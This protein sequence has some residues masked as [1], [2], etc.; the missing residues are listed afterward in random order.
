MGIRTLSGGGGG[1]AAAAAAAVAAVSQQGLE[2]SKNWPR[3]ISIDGRKCKQRSGI[4]ITMKL[5]VHV[6][7]FPWH[8]SRAPSIGKMV[9]ARKH[10][11]N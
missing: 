1:S 6:R 5:C 8:C 2:L 11:W 10:R 9:M 7:V 4:N 3:L